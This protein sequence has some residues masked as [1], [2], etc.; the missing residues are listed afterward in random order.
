MENRNFFR[1]LFWAL[2]AFLLWS[3]ISQRIWPPPTKGPA[4]SAGTNAPAGNVSTTGVAATTNGLAAAPGAA[5]TAPGGLAPAGGPA[6]QEVTLGQLDGGSNSP[7][8][9]KVWLSNEGAAIDTLRLTDHALKAG[10]DERYRLL[11]PVKEQDGLYR[12]FALE[13][14]L[15]DGQRVDVR[16]ARWHVA[17][18]TLDD[19]EAVVFSTQIESGGT[20]IIALERRFLLRQQPAKTL[21][22]DLELATTIRN[23]TDTPHDV[24]LVT[25]GPLGINREGRYGQD[26]KVFAAVRDE[27]VVA[28]SVHTF[29]DVAKK[30]VIELFPREDGDTS[31]ALWYG[32]ANVYFTATVMPAGAADAL[33]AIR[34]VQGVDLDEQKATEEDVTTRTAS[35]TLRVAPGDAQV[36]SESLYLGPKD[37]NVFED[38]A[39]KDYLALDL[40]Q[41]I[42]QGYGSCTFNFLTNLMIGLLNWLEGVV[43][44]FGIAIIILVIIVRTLLHPITKKTQVNMVRVQSRMSK[45][46]PKIEEL[47]RRHGNDAMKLN[48]ET[49]KLY[50]EEGVNPM[51]QGMSCLPMF[52]QMPIWVALYSSLSNNVAMR[53]EGFVWW[54]NDLTKPDEL[55]VFS[56]PLTVPI[57]GWKVAAFHLLPLLVGILMFAQQKLM[58]KPKHAVAA[59]TPQAQQAEQMQKIM[60]YMSLMMI[61]VFYNFP[62]GLNLYIMTS[63]LIG[64]LEQLYIRRH[65]S[66][67]DLEAQTVPAGGGKPRFK[68][69]ALLDWLQKQAE[70]AQKMPSRRDNEKRR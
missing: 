19:A 43:R 58:P 12:S 60:P 10:S 20:P 8:R 33:T 66:K 46:H 29:N 25:L 67:Q 14:V 48:Q 11:A 13:R 44:N 31:A 54:I 64:A 4:G 39:N 7:Y 2:L 21:R 41:Q 63:S 45:L 35:A 16:T 49:M 18:E 15:I 42:T 30:N 40:M 68:T 1:A 61:L 26:Q 32:G 6:A 37:R 57:L 38:P 56:H 9:M 27:G 59:D 3:M 47:K 50:R 62:S 51:S 53:G 55:Y 34:S 17:Q 70:Q 36:L 28:M 24:Q 69:P 5:T 65:I 22:Y 52:L 23:L